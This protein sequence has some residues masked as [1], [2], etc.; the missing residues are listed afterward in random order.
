MPVLTIRS[1]DE[2]ILFK[3]KAGKTDEK[4]AS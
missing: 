4:N 1:I 2:I 3:L